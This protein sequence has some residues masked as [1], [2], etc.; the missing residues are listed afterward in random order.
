MTIF[1]VKL[2][3]QKPLSLS[4]LLDTTLEWIVVLGGV[5]LEKL[6]VF[7][8]H[9]QLHRKPLHVTTKTSVYGVVRKFPHISTLSHVHLKQTFTLPLPGELHLLNV[10]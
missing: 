2:F 5:S 3:F 6:F 1:F 9:D 10:S 8:L 4:P 7:S